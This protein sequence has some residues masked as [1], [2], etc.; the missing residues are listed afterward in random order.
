MTTA[1]R[2]RARPRARQ[3]EVADRRAH[4]SC[5][6]AGKALAVRQ[7][8]RA[9]NFDGAD[10]RAPPMA[11]VSLAEVTQELRRHDRRRR[12]LARDRGRIL[13]RP[14]RADR[15]RQD[16][17]P[18]AGRRARGARPGHGHHRPARRDEIAAGGARRRLRLP[19]IFA[20]SASHG[21]RQSRLSVARAVAADDRGGDQAARS[22]RQRRCCASSASSTTARRACRAARCNA[23]RSGARSCDGPRSI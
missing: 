3:R 12:P 15:R 7:G 16:D 23:W 11:E 19:A 20:L 2:R 14:P 6:P 10:R 22:R 21:L 18:S 4:R 5:L 9:G 13:R 8:E 1:A 17:D